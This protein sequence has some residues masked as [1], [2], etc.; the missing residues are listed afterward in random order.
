M[1][2][3]K[4]SIACSYTEERRSNFSD[5]SEVKR[6]EDLRRAKVRG[7]MPMIDATSESE[8]PERDW[9]IRNAWNENPCPTWRMSSPEV[10][11]LSPKLRPGDWRCVASEVCDM[12]R[13][14]GVYA[15]MS[16]LECHMAGS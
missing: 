2:P 8:T 7:G 1:S 13:C 9:K 5:S 16:I 15:I 14:Y 11:A 4:R 6:P 10:A 3:S 12:Y